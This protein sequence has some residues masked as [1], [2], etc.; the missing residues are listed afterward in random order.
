M[1]KVMNEV[2]VYEFDG[3]NKVAYTKDQPPFSV[4]SHGGYR[5]FVVV[6]VGGHSYAVNGNDLVAAIVNAQNAGSR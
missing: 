1:I 4:H 2:T 6:Q 3:N 5:D